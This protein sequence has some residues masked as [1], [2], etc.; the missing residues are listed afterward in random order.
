M[1]EETILLAALKQ[2][3]PAER[4]AYLDTACAGDPALRERVDALLR[5]HANAHAGSDGPA[6]VPPAEENT[7]PNRITELLAGDADDSAAGS[8]VDEEL[9]AFLEP[10][11]EPGS[12]GRLDHFEILKVVGKGGMGVVFKARDT[13]LQCIVAIKVLAAHLAAS[14]AARQRFFR[15]A[16]AFA[17]VRDEHVV[18]IHAVSDDNRPVP[19]LVMEYIAGASLEKRIR[20]HGPLAV[21]EILRIGMQAAAGLAAAHKQGLIHRDIKPANILL[22]NGVERVKITDFGLAR[23]GRCESV[24]VGDACG[25]AAVHVAGAGAQRA[26]GSTERPFQPGQRAVRPLHRRAGILGRECGGGLEARV[27][28]H[29][30]TDPRAEPGHPGMARGNRQ[31]AAVERSGRASSVGRTN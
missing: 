27:R 10:S 9:L 16:R 3:S 18:S 24:A 19:Y 23:G 30:A 2:S 17:A 31:Q 6:I 1:T 22:E 5:T 15:E 20:K 28:G 14:G 13:R 11:T 12:L 4:T 21:K 7:E 29:A 25:H 26:A 8:L